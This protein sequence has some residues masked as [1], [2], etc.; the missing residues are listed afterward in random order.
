[1]LKMR[2]GG[3]ANVSDGDCDGCLESGILEG[4]RLRISLV[5]HSARRNITFC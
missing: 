2:E 1:M 4:T 3:K 5:H